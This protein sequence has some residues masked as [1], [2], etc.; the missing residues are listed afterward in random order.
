[1]PYLLTPLI[2]E[3]SPGMWFE[4][5]AYE[6][7]NIYSI[8]AGKMPPVNY[9]RHIIGAHSLTHLETPAHTIKDGR[10]LGSY[11]KE[12]L[13]RFYG[14]THVLK[15][16]GNKYL[17]KGNGVYHWE[18]SST[19]ITEGLQRI[20]LKEV[21][22]KL[23]ITT[24]YCPLNNQGY[25][26]PNYVLTLSQEAASLLVSNPDFQIYGTSWKS[27]DF[28]P[29]KPER[30]IHNTVFKTALIL[31][32]LILKDVP[33]GRYFMTAFPIPFKDASESP[34]APVLFTYEEI[35]LSI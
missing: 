22:R 32:N 13:G 7:Q 20:N 9:D 10:R 34:V 19:E 16:P 1:M 28:N 4:G 35:S 5:K 33:E 8:E 14:T 12:D 11:L 2:E 6:R 17:D 25:H 24:E 21:P 18:V 3:N 23:L 31:E 30:P 26:D 27:S 29:G 15:I